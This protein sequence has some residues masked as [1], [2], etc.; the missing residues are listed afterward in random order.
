MEEELEKKGERTTKQAGRFHWEQDFMCWVFSWAWYV[1]EVC[2]HTWTLGIVSPLLQKDV[3]LY[4]NGQLA[5]SWGPSAL[6][7]P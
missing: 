6:R 2:S 5:S 4:Q 7:I 3:S 1:V